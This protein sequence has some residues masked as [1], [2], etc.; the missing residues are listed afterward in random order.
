VVSNLVGNVIALGI[1]VFIAVYLWGAAP[2]SVVYL[3][4][5]MAAYATY[6]I[7]AGAWRII[8]ERRG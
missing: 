2:R 7:I 8:R 3:V 1:Y 6:S 5:A 4:C